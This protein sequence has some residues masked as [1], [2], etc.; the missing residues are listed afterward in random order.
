LDVVPF[1]NL[2]GVIV[3]QG[4]GGGTGDVEEEIHAYG[5]VRGVDE[6]G[7]VLLDQGANV[8]DFLIPSRRA[9]DYVLA[10][11]HAGFDV[12]EDA[13]RGSEVDDG[14]DV[15]K[16]FLTERGAGGVF[17]GSGNADVVLACGGHFRG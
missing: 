9:D 3:A 15:A 5:K 10:G 12:G 2:A 7:S 17:F 11:F 14:V 13:L 1:E 4:S 6:S 8:V 16:I